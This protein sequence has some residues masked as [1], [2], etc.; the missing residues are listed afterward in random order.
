M[1]IRGLMSF[2]HKNSTLYFENHQL[3]D[4]LVI[5][6]GYSLTCFLYQ[7]Y[8]NNTSAFGGD[9]DII[10]KF[11]VDFINLLLRCNVTPI[12]IFD[13]AYEQRKIKTIICRKIER[14]QVYSRPIKTSRC[15]PCFG[16]DVIFEILNDMDI[17]HIKC[18]FEADAEIVVL[19][20]ILNCPVISLDSDFYVNVVPYIPLDMIVLDFKSTEK[21]INCRLYKVEYLLN[22][23]GGLNIEYLPLVASLLGNDYIRPDTFSSLLRISPDT[24]N[25]GLKLKRIINWL[26]NQKD[27]NTAVQNMT[28]NLFYNKAYIFKQIKTIINEFK[29]KDS[30]YLS[31]LLRYKRMSKYQDSLK[32]YIKNEKSILPSWLECSYRKGI[33]NS[34][35]MNIFASNTIFFRTQIDDFEKPPSF[36]ISFKILKRII[37]LILGKNQSVQCFGRIN[38]SNLGQYKLTAY[39]KKPCV[40]LADL[41][42]TNLEYRKNI[43][44]DLIGMKFLNFFKIP[45]EWELFIIILIYWINQTNNHNSVQVHALIICAIILNIHK[46]EVQS[47]HKTLEKESIIKENIT[48]V[49]NEDCIKAKSILSDYFKVTSYNDKNMYTKIMHS[50]AQFQYCAYY[51][52]ILNSLLN[53]PYKQCRIDNFFKG[54]LLY[55]L[56]VKLEKEKQPELFITKQLFEKL[57]SINIVY[58]SLTNQL[59]ILLTVSKPRLMPDTRNCFRPKP[60]RKYNKSK[61]NY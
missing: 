55:N 30:K 46:I 35:V 4:T 40:T 29:R 53:F 5:V 22:Q 13:G 21:F 52:M 51:F 10:T 16:C 50:L 57:D 34:E 3:K 54:S 9:Y 58:Q 17:P 27:V 36:K 47:Q 37:G 31:F 42:K 12:F 14:I 6:D 18:D 41:N 11:C 32:K 38:G 28:R 56:S 39:I 60:K 48:K 24:Y 59:E 2:M 15:M 43:I 49:K 23:F 25:C 61:N 7:L 44:L 19:A 8:E 20:K 33:I 1:G 26:K 45:K